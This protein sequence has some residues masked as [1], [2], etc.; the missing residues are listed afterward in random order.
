M[1]QRAPCKERQTRECRGVLGK[2]RQVPSDRIFEK[3]TI[4]QIDCQFLKEAGS[5]RWGSAGGVSG[6]AVVPLGPRKGITERR[7][8]KLQSVVGGKQSGSPEVMG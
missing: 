5:Q 3:L 7:Q 6:T 2:R 4:S 8:G 1:G